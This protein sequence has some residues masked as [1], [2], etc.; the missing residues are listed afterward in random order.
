[1]SGC[2]TKMLKLL[3]RTAFVKENL[4]DFKISV[5]RYDVR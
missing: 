5:V 2:Y 3:S 1:M 4:F